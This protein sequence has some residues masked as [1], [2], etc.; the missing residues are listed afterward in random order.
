MPRQRRRTKRAAVSIPQ[1]VEWLYRVRCCRQP[2]A[3]LARE[4]H[5]KRMHRQDMTACFDS[6]RQA[7]REGIRAAERL[8]NLRGDRPT[9]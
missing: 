3:A 6:D 1:C 2:V 4:L 8:L 5:A 9:A 7:I